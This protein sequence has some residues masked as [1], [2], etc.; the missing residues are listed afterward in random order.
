[1]IGSASS[2]EKVLRMLEA[3]PLPNLILMDIGLSGPADGI[4]TA[5][6]IRLR[7]SIPLIFVTAYTSDETIK[8][9]EEV[10]PDGYIGKPFL[11]DVILALIRKV[12]DS[13]ST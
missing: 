11:D 9:M 13:R 3:G 2:G 6:V 10:S 7:F 4:E 12:I 5:S 8:R 1:M